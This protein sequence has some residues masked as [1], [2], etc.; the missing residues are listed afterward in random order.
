MVDRVCEMM[1]RAGGSDSVFPAT[2]LYNEGWLLRL[3]LDAFD[4]YR[5]FGHP[6]APA[7]GAGWFSEALLPSAFLPSSRSDPLGESWTHADGV[8]G[9]FDVGRT[10]RA[11]L[12][13]AEGASQFV[14]IEAK[15][16]SKL[17]PGISHARY[18]DQAARNVA[19][20]AEVLYRARKD[21]SEL[22]HLAFFV[23]APQ[24][25]IDDGAFG[26]LVT[27]DSVRSKVERRVSE[28]GGKRGNWLADAFDPLAAELD[29]GCT[30]W[31]Q[32]LKDIAQ[33]SRSTAESLERFYQDCV[34][35]NQPTRGPGER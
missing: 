35:Y 34:R 28:Y 16:F 27:H 18:Y 4:R 23:V 14:V 22:Q 21:P 25:Q 8:V 19:C 17:S 10:G 7:D 29:L 2:V 15:M 5:P 30:S 13:L 26:D 31:E 32:L 9:H 1:A 20:M 33:S 6:L 12:E 3:V 11:D 24:S